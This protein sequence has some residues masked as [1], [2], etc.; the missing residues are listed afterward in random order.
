MNSYGKTVRNIRQTKGYLQKDVYHDI[1]AK[2]FAIRF[3]KGEVMLQ[4]DAFL[5]VLAN[6]NLSVTE[7]H[8][9]HNNYQFDR[10]Q[11]VWSIFSAAV[12]QKNQVRLADFYLSYSE[13]SINFN[14][15]L[16]YL[17]NIA[18]AIN[19]YG[20]ATYSEHV[21]REQL[22][23]IQNYLLGQEEWT[24]DETALFTN[25]YE[26]FPREAQRK[27]MT[28][29]F[30]NLRQYQK[31]PEHSQRVTNLLS[32]Y[33]LHCY[34]EG[35]YT[36]GNKWYVKLQSLSLR[37]EELYLTIRRDICA[38]YYYFIK[39]EYSR[40]QNLIDDATLALA[41]V[42]N[43]REASLYRQDYK[44]FKATFKRE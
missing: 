38:G 42:G 40:A 24:L 10:T 37:K 2:S 30:Q 22:L 18:F 27:L 19:K 36:E 31:Y 26:V 21:P 20:E 9:I 44:K 11:S 39:G 14:R 17:A 28:L 29:C 13:S 6:L 12:S 1:V 32:H 34:D 15:V 16:A 8:F 25:F 33:I 43:E 5:S 23:F 7:F 41:L 4:Y 35:S 3:E